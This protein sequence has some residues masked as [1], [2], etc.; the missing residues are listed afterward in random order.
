MTFGTVCKQVVA[1]VRYGGLTTLFDKNPLFTAV[2][3]GNIKL[4]DHLV[5][6][7]N[8][9]NQDKDGNTALHYATEHKDH[10]KSVE[11]TKML[12]EMKANPNIPNKE[13]NTPFNIASG[14][15]SLSNML[16]L[17]ECEAKN[18]KPDLFQVQLDKNINAFSYTL[19]SILSK[20]EIMDLSPQ[21]N[22]HLKKISDIVKSLYEVTSHD[23][24]T[25]C[26][27]NNQ[28]TIYQN[29]LANGINATDVLLSGVDDGQ[30]SDY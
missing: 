16:L 18:T 28:Y 30:S 10:P 25:D 5:T 4:V 22:A 2:K 24:T 20:N 15:G 8:V 29:V 23:Y 7:G 19:Q 13:N 12:L 14:N 17:A 11:I 6:K 1:K 3:T 27:F 26:S 9:N 21:A